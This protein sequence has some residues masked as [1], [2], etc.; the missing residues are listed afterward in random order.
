M[1]QAPRRRKSAPTVSSDESIEDEGTK[2]WIS[3]PEFPLRSIYYVFVF[4]EDKYHLTNE[5]MALR[6]WQSDTWTSILLSR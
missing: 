4:V 5:S 6:Y 1:E 3:A 2:L